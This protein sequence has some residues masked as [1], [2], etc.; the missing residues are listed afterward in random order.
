MKRI[1]PARP[2]NP[3][4]ARELGE[5]LA[6][7]F[8]FHNL[9]YCGEKALVLNMIDEASKFHACKVIHQAKV[10]TYAELGNCVPETFRSQVCGASRQK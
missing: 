5:V 4:R 7:D 1:A 8:S 3:V 9:E 6:V 2:A 10:S